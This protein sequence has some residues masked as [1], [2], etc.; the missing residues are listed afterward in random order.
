MNKNL[1][2]IILLS[3]IILLLGK[4]N[5]NFEYGYNHCTRCGRDSR[6]GGQDK[7]YNHQL[8]LCC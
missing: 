7:I 3:L 2:I 6:C 1:F 4:R 5:E 8:K